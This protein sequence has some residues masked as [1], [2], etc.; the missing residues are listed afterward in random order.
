M[1]SAKKGTKTWISVPV[2]LGRDWKDCSRDEGS[3]ASW[4]RSPPIFR[5]T[6]TKGDMTGTKI[7]QFGEELQGFFKDK[8][9]VMGLGKTRFTTWRNWKAPLLELSKEASGEGGFTAGPLYFVSQQLAKLLQD[10]IRNDAEIELYP[11]EVCSRGKDGEAYFCLNVMSEIDATNRDLSLVTMEDGKI[12]DIERLVID[13]S[14]AVCDIF[15]L[16]AW[17]DVLC[18]SA[19]LAEAIASLGLANVSILDPSEIVG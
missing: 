3:S 19:R 10:E 14:K 2:S 9:W 18:I 8:N 6:S 13:E 16:D 1:A 4:R 15:W 12:E 7:L 17:G 11:A 5:S